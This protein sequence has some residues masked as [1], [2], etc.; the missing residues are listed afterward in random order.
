[1]NEESIDKFYQRM[2]QAQMLRESRDSDELIGSGKHWEGKLTI[3]EAPDFELK[4]NFG[5][6]KVK[7]ISKPVIWNGEI[8]WDAWVLIP[9]HPNHPQSEMTRMLYKDNNIDEMIKINNNEDIPLFEEDK[10]FSECV[11][12]LHQEIQ[13]LFN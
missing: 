13:D 6:E 9:R 12:T 3:P 10:P 7:C 11:A 4:D 5:L 8:V 1:V 2:M